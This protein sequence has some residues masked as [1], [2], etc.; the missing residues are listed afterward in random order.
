MGQV[1]QGELAAHQVSAQYTYVTDSG[2]ETLASPAQVFDVAQNNCANVASPARVDSAVGWNCYVGGVRQNDAPIPFGVS[3]TEPDTGVVADGSAVPTENTT[4]DD[5]WYIQELYVNNGTGETVLTATEV[6]SSVWRKFANSQAATSPYQNY[7]Y[8]FD[9]RKVVV[10][11]LAGHGFNANYFYVRRPRNIR[12]DSSV[13]PFRQPGAELFIR[14]NALSLVHLSNH[15]YTASQSWEA[16]AEKE[17][18]L[19]AQSLNKKNGKKNQYIRPVF[20]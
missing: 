19:I 5:V 18:L 17:R 2:S 15:E 14:Y 3:Y 13:I 11:P 10:R 9:G 4:G 6:G 7:C 1:A 8:D 12:Y 20:R 16:R